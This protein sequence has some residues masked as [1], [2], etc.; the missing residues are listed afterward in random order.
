MYNTFSITASNKG[1]VVSVDSHYMGRAQWIPV[2]HVIPSPG[3]NVL[4]YLPEDE[5]DTLI[6]DCMIDDRTWDYCT[7]IET[8]EPEVTHWMP[9]P[10]VPNSRNTIQGA[11]NE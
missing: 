4:C 1:L 11:I 6:V 3:V 2:S 9:L 10:E 5:E 8:G 7:N